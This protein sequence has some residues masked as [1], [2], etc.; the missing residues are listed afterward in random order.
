MSAIKID[1]KITKY[2]VSKPVDKAEAKVAEAATEAEPKAASARNSKGKVI[3]LTEEVQRPEV[4][5]G[6][7]YEIETPHSD[8]A[9]YVTIN[10]IVLNEGGEHAQRR[11][12][13]DF[14]NS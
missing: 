9:M 11:P 7:T 1:R 4:L 13:E 10:A 8:H 2:R 14:I 12:F 6:S 5:I 3:R